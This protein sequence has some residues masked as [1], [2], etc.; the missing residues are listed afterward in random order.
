MK[1]LLYPLLVFITCISATFNN[2]CNPD[3]NENM[4]S[5]QWP[6]GSQRLENYMATDVSKNILQGKQQCIKPHNETDECFQQHFYDKQMYLPS[7]INPLTR[8]SY[9]QQTPNLGCINQNTY[10]T[11]VQ[12]RPFYEQQAQLPSFIQPTTRAVIQQPVQL[13][14]YVQPIQ[15][16]TRPAC[17]PNPQVSFVQ[18]QQ[19]SI[20]PQTFNPPPQA[21]IPQQMPIQYSPQCYKQPQQNFSCQVPPQQSFNT[22]KPRQECRSYQ[23]C[24]RE[25]QQIQDFRCDINEPEYNRFSESCTPYSDYSYDYDR[26]YKSNRKRRKNY[27]KYQDDDDSSSERSSRR[28]SKDVKKLLKNAFYIVDPKSQLHYQIQDSVKRA[29]KVMLVGNNGNGRYRNR[30]M[31]NDDD[32]EGTQNIFQDTKFSPNRSRLNNRKLKSK[33]LSSLRE[34]KI[35][36]NELKKSKKKEKISTKI[37]AKKQQLENDSDEEIAADLIDDEKQEN[38]QI[39]T[40]QKSK[41]K[42][43]KT[44]TQNLIDDK[45]NLADE[46]ENL[47]DDKEKQEDNTDLINDD[48]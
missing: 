21:L 37:K 14:S 11:P 1:K 46:K 30:L 15:P 8:P 32:D 27:K 40:K 9:E 23:P 24:T 29:E 18:P 43:E 5:T 28:S 48:D 44:L 3:V 36:K 34:N 7:N 13:P 16:T 35:L 4:C 12:P 25:S 38:L 41:L 31:D 26:P 42:G 47:V 20:Q 6:V 33:L 45:E 2:I 22:C 39:D 19:V 10:S 17:Q